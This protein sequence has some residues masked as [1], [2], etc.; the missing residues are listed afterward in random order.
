[1][2]VGVS[3]SSS[4]QQSPIMKKRKYDRTRYKCPMCNEV[5]AMRK[6]PDEVVFCLDCAKKIDRYNESR[7]KPLHWFVAHVEPSFI[8]SSSDPDFLPPSKKP[9]IKRHIPKDA[10]ECRTSIEQAALALIASQHV[11]VVAGAG[12]SV[13]SGLPD[14]RGR[15]G[16]YR[17]AGPDSEIK[18]EEVNFHENEPQVNILRCWGFVTSMI[19]KF[20]EKKPHTGYAVLRNILLKKE[21]FVFTSNVDGYFRRDGFEPKRIFE[22]HGCIETLQCTSVGEKW[23]VE[24][25][26]SLSL[27]RLKEIASDIDARCIRGHRGRKA[28]WIDAI[29][30]KSG[31]CNASVWDWP[32]EVPLPRL[33]KSGGVRRIASRSEIPRCIDCGRLARPNVS[34]VTDENK[35][36]HHMRHK[37]AQQAMERWIEKCA[38][39]SLVIL[40]IGCGTSAHSL[41]DESELLLRRRCRDS[42][43]TLIRI[44]PG[45]A[46]VPVCS[47]GSRRCIGI[48][49]KAR[50]ALEDIWKFIKKSVQ[51]SGNL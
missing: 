24:E 46:S 10:E 18:M 41:R 33:V 15:K 14:F 31:A 26:Q 49:E 38:K 7:D 25:L 22:C 16:F 30:K 23:S 17:P 44:D 50:C 27:G 35:H 12:M 43:T 21:Y 48:K 1:M 42:L 11:L 39:E 6:R 40:E 3:R 2:D 32:P 36:I 13:D 34:H 45:N 51:R 28:T 5:L 4:S 37:R 47:G 19:S 8:S 29:S 20:R 9:F